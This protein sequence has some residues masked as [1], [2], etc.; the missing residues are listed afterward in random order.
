M[1]PRTL[2]RTLCCLAGAAALACH[3]QIPLAGVT[4]ATGPGA[5]AGTGFKNGYRMAIDEV[6]G[7]GGVLGQKLVLTQFDID[8]KPDAAKEAMVQAV[9]GKPFAIL[10]PVFSGLTLATMPVTT[11]TGIPHFT[12]GEAA[13]LTR[14]FHP[15]LLR[16][17]LSQTASA[18]RLASFVAYGLEPRGLALMFID[19]DLGRDGKAALSEVFKRRNTNVSFERAIKPGQTD[20]SKDV[21]DLINAQTDALLF[22]TTE[23]EAIGLLKELRKQGFSKPVFSDGLVA[24]QTVIDGA[25]GA[26]EGVLAHMTASVDAPTPQVQSFTARYIARYGARPDHNAIKGFFAVQL[27]KAGLELS[28]RVDQTQFLKTV[29]DTRFDVRKYPELLSSTGY[30]FFGEL[31]RESYFVVIRE[32]RPRV[33]ATMRSIEGGQVELPNHSQIAMNSAEFRRT[34]AATLPG[35]ASAPVSAHPIIKTK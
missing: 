27:I 30:D 33:L 20:F 4:E 28:G 3:A 22:Y 14:K 16:S 15:T 35:A 32:G 23:T 18:P 12:G 10:G 13:S 24:A 9:A 29:K 25:Q 1:T 5:L 11:A 34:V 21:T 2:L 7:S 6:N 31:N 17:S 8:T 19:N 26:A